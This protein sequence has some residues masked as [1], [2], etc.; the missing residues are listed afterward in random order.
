M[1][2]LIDKLGVWPSLLIGGVFLVLGLL[3]LNHVVDNIWLF[4]AEDRLDL[5]QAVA[6]GRTDSNALLASAYTEVILAFLAA[7]AMAIIG[8]FLPLFYVINKRFV[9]GTPN[10]FVCLRQAMWVGLWAV[11]CLWLQM[12]RALGIPVALLVAVVFI[13]AELMMQ[14]RA[15]TQATKSAPPPPTPSADQA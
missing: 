9:G 15:R 11:F 1:Q 4:N 13:L 5:V 6:L 8:L 7:I 10:L 12:N 14:I 2:R 3:S